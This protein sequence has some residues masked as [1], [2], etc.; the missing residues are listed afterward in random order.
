[1]TLTDT[2]KASAARK[3]LEYVKDGMVVGLGTG[4]TATFAIQF[5]GEMVRDGLKICGV[6]TSRARGGVAAPPPAPP[7]SPPFFGEKW[8]AM[9]ERS[10]APPLRE[11]VASWR[12]R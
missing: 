7:L 1:M 2:E 5:L 4:S 9:F 11:P 8:P 12:V 10:A 6:P 3:S